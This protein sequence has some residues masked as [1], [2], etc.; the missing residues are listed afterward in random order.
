[1]AIIHH[2]FKWCE[3]KFMKE[4]TSTIVVGFLEKEFFYRFV[5]QNMCLLTRV[6]NGWQNLIWC[7][8][9]SNSHIDSLLHIGFIAMEWW[10]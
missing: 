1:M 4:Q 9:I 3:A 10:K 2:Y 7:V 5:S 6:G 8:R